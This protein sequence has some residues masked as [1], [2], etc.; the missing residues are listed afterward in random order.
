MPQVGDI[1]H[2][3]DIGKSGNMTY[4][5][6]TCESC[7]KARWIDIEP[8]KPR[9]HFCH[10]CTTK[11]E[12]SYNWKG[13]RSATGTGYYY[14]LPD[15]ED[16]GFFDQ[17]MNHK[18]YILEHR[19]VVAKHLGRCLHPWEI[20]HHKNHIRGDNRIENLQLVSTDKHNQITLMDNKIRFL[21]REISTLKKENR[22]LKRELGE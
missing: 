1:S 16:G 12:R 14:V 18:G 9:S 22:R 10:S 13:G 15:V 4:V 17:M 19:Y 2:A 6:V 20:I 3:K 21:K 11:R 7:G 8:H 5:W